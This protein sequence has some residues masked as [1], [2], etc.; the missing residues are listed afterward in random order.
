MKTSCHITKDGKEYLNMHDRISNIL[1]E[2]LSRFEE[3]VSWYD[4]LKYEHPY[5]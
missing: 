5:L 4:S 1:N 3:F 2:L